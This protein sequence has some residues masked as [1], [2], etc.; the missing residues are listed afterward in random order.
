MCVFVCVMSSQILLE[1]AMNVTSELLPLYQRPLR[2]ALSVLPCLF[3]LYVNVVMLFAL[4][5]KPLFRESSRYNLFGNLLFI[6]SLQLVLAMSLYFFAVTR[7]KLTSYVCLLFN[8]TA[9]I[10]TKLS[11][12][13]LAVMSL[14][15]YVAI[16][17]PLRHAEIATTRRTKVIIAVMWTAASLDSLAQLFVFISLENVSVSELRICSRDTL[18]KLKIY[19]T[20]NKTFTIVCFVLV[21]VIIIYTYIAILITVRAA[22]HNTSGATKAHKTVLLHLL[23]LC[24]CLSSTLFYTIVTSWLLNMNPAKANNI[25][26]ILFLSLII[27]PRC[28][29]PLV[30]GLRDQKL[31]EI[32]TYYFT[33]GLK[34]QIRPFN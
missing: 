7:A 26:Y 4:S 1:V 8:L 12:L 25:K 34:N 6:D 11:P 5:R 20:L 24:L 28:L 21:S 31:R 30:Y 18:F 15:R 27:F 13:N 9:S 22:S 23:Q 14:E 29:S 32:F 17:F 19:A 16:C 3:F 10:A 2:V 33:F